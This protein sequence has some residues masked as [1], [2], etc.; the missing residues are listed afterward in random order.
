MQMRFSNCFSVYVLPL[1]ERRHVFVVAADD[2]LFY[3]LS[4][5]SYKKIFKIEI[6]KCSYRIGENL[7][8]LM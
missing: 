4:S 7:K 3:V 2:L 5:L 1:V 8:N 6:L